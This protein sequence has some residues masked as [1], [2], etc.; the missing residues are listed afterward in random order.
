MARK[1][2]FVRRDGRMRRATEWV[3]TTEARTTLASA[4]AAA[5]ISVGSAGLLAATPFTIIR[6]IMHWSARSDQTGASENWGV[7]IGC[8]VVSAPAAALGIT[9]VPT[10]FTDLGSDLWYLHSI[11]DGRFE[12]ISGVGTDSN[13]VSPE[14]GV[15]IDSRG[16]RKVEDGDD[17]IL[18]A[19]NDSVSAGTT[20]YTAGRLLIKLH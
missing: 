13:S 14:G 18:V 5:L 11:L 4:N 12:F 9:A 8:A 1:S 20:V 17:I 3:A 2:G 15:N 10:P 19:E 7:A 16:A 6:S